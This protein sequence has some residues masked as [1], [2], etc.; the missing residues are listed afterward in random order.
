MRFSKG[1]HITPFIVGIL[2]GC[3]ILLFVLTVFDT[4]WMQEVIW[5]CAAIYFIY[6]LLRD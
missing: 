2:G 5:W 3:T 6:W 1:D 4:E